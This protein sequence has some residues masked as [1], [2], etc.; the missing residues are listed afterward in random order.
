M[1]EVALAPAARWTSGRPL[2]WRR[3]AISSN[4]ASNS[5]ATRDQSRSGSGRVDAPAKP[6]DQ[7]RIGDQPLELGGERH[8]V[9]R[10]EQQAELALAQRLLV[11]GQARGHRHGARRRARAARAAARARRRPRRPRR[12]SRAPGAAPR[13]RRPGRRA[14]RAR[15]AGAT[16]RRRG[17]RRGSRSQIVARQS[18]SVGSRRSARRNSRS[19]PRSSSAENTISGGPVVRAGAVQ[20]VGARPD[21]AVVAR[22]VALDQVARGGEAGGAPVEPAEQ[23][24]DDLARHLRRDEALGGRVEGADVERARVAQRRRG[25]ARARTARARERSRARRG[26]AGPRACARRRAAATPSRRAGTAATARPPAPRRSPARRK[27]VGVGAQRAATFARPSRTS[28]RES[29]GATTTTRWPRAQSSSESRSTKRL[30]SW[31]CSQGHG[32]DLG[33]R[34]GLATAPKAAYVGELG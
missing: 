14:A 33:D 6:R 20:Q 12:S 32:R 24:L 31:C 5:S 25:G 29:E 9:A 18:R 34:E 17:R 7:L 4:S 30:T 11:L 28:S 23:Q 1:D 16:A 10:L 27:R 13:S 21:H 19:A 3:A 26:R 2:P 22:E 8:R 15:A